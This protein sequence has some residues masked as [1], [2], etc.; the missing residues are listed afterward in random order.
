MS[1]NEAIITKDADK[2]CL[3]S[4]IFGRMELKNVSAVEAEYQASSCCLAVERAR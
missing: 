3:A 2:M 4:V 1:D